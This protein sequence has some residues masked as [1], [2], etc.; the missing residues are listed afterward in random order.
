MIHLRKRGP[1]LIRFAAAAVGGA[2][3]AW[4]FQPVGLWWLAWLG[5]AGLLVALLGRPSW[6]ATV[7]MAVI[8]GFTTS[9]IALPWISEFVGAMPYVALSVTLGLMQIPGVLLARFILGADGRGTG[10]RTPAA[11]PWPVRAV[12]A[13]A[14]ILAGEALLARWPFGGFP[15]LRIG[16]GQLGSPLDDAAVL[17]GVALVGFLAVLVSA[18]LASFVVKQ[19]ATGLVLILLPLAVGLVAQPAAGENAATVRIAAVQG[20]VPRLGM[21]FNAQRRAVLKNHADATRALAARVR[22]GAEPRPDLVVWPENS[23]DVSPFRDPEAARII[24]AAAKD[25]KAPI[26]VGTFTYD[27][28][29]QNTM[30]LWDPVDGPVD[31]QRHEKIYLQPFGETMPFRDLL[32]RITPL[33]DRAGDMTPG[34]GDGVIRVDLDRGAEGGGEGGADENGGEARGGDDGGN[35][36]RE[37]QGEIG[38]ANGARAVVDTIA[39]GIATCYEVVFDDAFRDAVNNGATIL[40][41]PTNNATFG[42]TDMTYQQLAMSR[43]RAIEFDRAV[44]VA[45]TSGVSAIVGPDGSVEQETGIFEQHVLTADLPLRDNLTFAARYGGAVEWA[46][47]ALAAFALIAAVRRAAAAVAAAREDEHQQDSRKER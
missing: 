30:V 36:T 21:D 41:T 7:G 10:P 23:S 44:V 26:I 22:D 45:A 11:V 17:G 37:G 20:N 35:G 32:R 25:I 43:M 14:A 39:M 40:A 6:G 42:F 24:D 27:D 46:I 2:F 18:G 38:A 47:V 9:M 16:W 34:S 31:G 28:G 5:V 29:V 8:W 3:V 13:A 33:V 4:S 19:W 15:W 1:V 12:G